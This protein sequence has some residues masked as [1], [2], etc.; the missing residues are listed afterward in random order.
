MIQFAKSLINL[1][2]QRR[3]SFQKQQTESIFKR[4]QLQNASISI[5]MYLTAPSTMHLGHSAKYIEIVIQVK[6]NTKP[7]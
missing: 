4:K 3:D 2:L 6:N 5:R 1:S 7:S